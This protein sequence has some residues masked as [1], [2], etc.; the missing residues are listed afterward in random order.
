[1]L[2]PCYSKI[3]VDLITEFRQLTS[4]MLHTALDIWLFYT[5]MYYWSMYYYIALISVCLLNTKKTKWYIHC[6]CIFSS[7]WSFWFFLRYDR[8]SMNN[9]G[10]SLSTEIFNKEIGGKNPGIMD[11]LHSWWNL[12]SKVNGIFLSKTINVLQFLKYIF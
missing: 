9:L 3:I 11:G 12:N 5:C 8:L 2:Y 10:W 1:M 6:D 4:H 7:L